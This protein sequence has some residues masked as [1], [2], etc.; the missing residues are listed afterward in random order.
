LNMNYL[1]TDAILQRMS[2]AEIINVLKRMAGMKGAFLLVGLDVQDREIMSVRLSEETVHRFD[3]TIYAEIKDFL[4]DIGYTSYYSKMVA[5]N[6]DKD[7]AKEMLKKGRGRQEVL[8]KILSYEEK[9]AMLKDQI[10]VTRMLQRSLDIEKLFNDQEQKEVFKEILKMNN[11]FALSYLKEQWRYVSYK[12]DQEVIE[13]YLAIL[14]TVPSKY[15]PIDSYKMPKKTRIIL[16][17]NGVTGDRGDVHDFT[18]EELEA[19]GL[20]LN[21]IAE[22]LPAKLKEWELIELA[23]SDSAFLKKNLEL[24]PKDYIKHK[25]KDPEFRKEFIGNRTLRDNRI[26]NE[27]LERKLAE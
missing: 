25:F 27:K 26:A 8:G 17:S 2:N 4:F 22:M 11:E 16:I 18:R 19:G 9:L 6:N 1:F 24:Y 15:A 20:K 10:E 13:E 12:N 14:E 7:M 23:N 5:T 21:Q 3:P